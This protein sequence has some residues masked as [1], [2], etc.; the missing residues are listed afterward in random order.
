MLIDE[1]HIQREQYYEQ[2]WSN[3]VKNLVLKWRD[4]IKEMSELH[5]EAGYRTKIKHNLIGLPTVII[6]L[7]MTVLQGIIDDTYSE[8]SIRKLIILNSVMYGITTAFTGVYGWLDLGNQYSLHFQYSARYYELIIKIDQELTYRKTPV[9]V[10]LTELRVQIE[11][12]NL[13]APDMPAG[14]CGC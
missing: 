4:H 9:S 8:E 11:N 1:E 5:E 2:E 3:N 14:I 13:T 12:L 7:I 10:F 6:P